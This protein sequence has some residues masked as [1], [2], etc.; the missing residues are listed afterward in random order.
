M[1]WL[2]TSSGST[3]RRTIAYRLSAIAA[4]TARTTDSEQPTAA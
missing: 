3:A 1:V 4:A 2:V